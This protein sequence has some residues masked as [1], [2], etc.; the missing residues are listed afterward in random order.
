MSISKT[1][2]AEVY[3]RDGHRCV[4][5]GATND[6][7]L[8]HIIPSAYG[9]NNEDVNLQTL[10]SPCNHAKGNSVPEDYQKAVAMMA[11]DGVIRRTERALKKRKRKPRPL[12]PRAK[13]GLLHHRHCDANYCFCECP[14]YLADHPEL[15]RALRA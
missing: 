5:C 6:L 3:E 10:C 11:R 15:A 1:T 12:V 7:T 9:G 4:E 8:D 14:V 13:Y 2:R